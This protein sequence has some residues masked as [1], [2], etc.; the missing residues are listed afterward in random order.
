MSELQA[1]VDAAILEAKAIV[2]AEPVTRL[3]LGEVAKV[4][5]R[6]AARHDLFNLRSFPLPSASDQDIAVTTLHCDA[7]GGFALQALVQRYLADQPPRPAAQAHMHHTWAVAAGVAGTLINKLHACR[8]DPV[9]GSD[10]IETIG[11]VALRTG[12]TLAM[13]PHDI[14]SVAAVPDDPSLHLILYGRRLGDVI[15]FSP[16][17]TRSE[18]YLVTQVG[19]RR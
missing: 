19:G 12:V 14:H 16:D 11:S 17:G 9:A 18:V 7:D 4:M 15:L 10:H 13:M 5:G 2:R 8:P 3:R 6:L 1:A